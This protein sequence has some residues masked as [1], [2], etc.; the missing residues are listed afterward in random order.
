MTTDD[1]ATKLNAIKTAPLHLD[2]EK[3][4]PD[5]C[6]MEVIAHEAAKA[7]AED[8]FKLDLAKCVVDCEFDG[9]FKHVEVNMRGVNGNV[10]MILGTVKRALSR[11]GA[12]PFQLS[13]FIH[14]AQSG[15]YEHAL[16][17][18]AKWVTIVDKPINR[19]AASA[20]N[21]LPKGDEHA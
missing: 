10:F 11:A 5:A 14:R 6:A 19:C 15:D 13:V 18:C 9:I 3:L 21:N 20:F 1:M 12:T 17:T 8:R 4:R 7:D 16:S 2:I